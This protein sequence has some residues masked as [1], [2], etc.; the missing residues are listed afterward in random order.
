MSNHI[1][2]LVWNSSTDTFFTLNQHGAA[3]NM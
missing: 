1:M 3:L 2:D